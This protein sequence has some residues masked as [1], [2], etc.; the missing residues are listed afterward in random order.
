[1][2]RIE[3]FQTIT[4]FTPNPMQ[5]AM[6]D[7]VSSDDCA[8]LLKSPTG[9]GKTESV[10]VPS[11]AARRRLF[12]V[13]PARS[14]VE[15]QI[16]RI[17]S[18]F[19]RLSQNG[20]RFAL[21]VDTGGQSSRRLFENGQEITD[22]QFNS[23]RHLYDG[24]VIV[25]TLDKFLYRF[26]GFGDERKSYIFPFRIFHGLRRNLFVFD[27]AHAY[28]D[29]AFTNFVRLIKSLYTANLNVVLMTATM[30]DGYARELGF[31]DTVD[32]LGNN[33]PYPK[34]LRYVPL[35]EKTAVAD[36]VIAEART[37]QVSGKRLIVTVETVED[38]VQVWEQLG[39]PL[40]YHGRLDSYQRRKV[41]AEL[42]RREQENVEYTLVTTSAIEVGCDLNADCLISEICNPASLIQ[43]AGRCNRRGD[44]AGAEIVVI[45][46]AI[47]KFLREIGDEQEQAFIHALGER[48]GQTF[49][50]D[51]FFRFMQRG[52]AFDYRAEIL[53]DMLFE[54]VYEARLE[55][56]PLHDKG[57]VVT[58]S[59]EPSVTLT[60][61]KERMSHAISV[62]ISRC[63]ARRK[64]DWDKECRVYTRHFYKHG[65]E[66]DVAFKELQWGGCAYF[67]DLVIEAPLADPEQ[68]WVDLPKPFLKGYPE[69]YRETVRYSRKDG[70]GEAWLFY[71]R[72]QPE[73]DVQTPTLA[74]T[75]ET[76]AAAEEETDADRHNS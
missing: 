37:R 26:F 4:S 9:S 46:D 42:K 75:T 2:P 63:A 55:N 64:E 27:E 52:V 13:Y 30:P 48:S 36:A 8:V 22:Q 18:V 25:T 72:W 10:L 21:V 74:V 15:D 65:N 3:E 61:D 29:T 70:S 28:E 60:T 66:Y 53:F 73:E 58:R 71:L 32:F 47:K 59:W 62:P 11:L 6:W 69:G 56:K 35:P 14:L 38:A 67:R 50:P 19:T 24:D 68:G 49:R 57:L 40:L 7:R 5:A 20:K 43:R 1:M 51:D 41:Y 44:R 12:M 31:L 54:Y 17:E 39:K 23:R 76:D 33:R 16:G 34:T 45:G